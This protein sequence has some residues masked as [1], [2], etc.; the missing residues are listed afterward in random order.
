MHSHPALHIQHAAPECPLPGQCIA[1]NLCIRF[2]ILKKAQQ[3]IRRK[4]IWFLLS[5]IL[6]ADSINMG[7][8]QDDLLRISFGKK[9]EHISP[10]QRVIQ[11]RRL[12]DQFGVLLKIRETRQDFKHPSADVRFAMRGTV[13]ARD[14]DEFFCQCFNLL[15]L[16]QIFDFLVHI[17]TPYAFI[18]LR[19]KVIQWMP[20][21]NFSSSVN[22]ISWTV[23][24]FLRIFSLMRR[25]WAREITSSQPIAW[26]L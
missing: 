23:S 2:V 4:S 10:L 24:P 25:F 21:P 8:Q 6:D 1:L 9:C 11:Q 12:P 17:V 7:M 16:R 18:L 20:P 13:H 15:R 19:G 5:E 3:T 14:L 22:S 26:T